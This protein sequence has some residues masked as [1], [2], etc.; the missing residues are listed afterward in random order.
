ML[1]YE[2]YFLTE[3]IHRYETR[4]TLHKIFSVDLHCIYQKAFI[5]ERLLHTSSYV[6]TFKL[7]YAR[8]CRSDI[9]L[10]LII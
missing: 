9:K 3:Q 1:Q 8:L 6:Y 5:L 4:P 7:K 2:I 10:R